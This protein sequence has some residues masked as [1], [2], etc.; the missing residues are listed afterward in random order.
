[1]IELRDQMQQWLGAD[2]TGVKIVRM[3]TTK[4]D[5]VYYVLVA[6]FLGIYC[7]KWSA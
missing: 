1:M 4:H 3:I 7:F 6:S 5:C 2:V